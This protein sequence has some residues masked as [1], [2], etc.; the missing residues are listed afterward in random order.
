[1]TDWPTIVI[2]F[3]AAIGLI[4]GILIWIFNIGHTAKSAAEDV[5]DI[6]KRLS[7]VEAKSADVAVLGAQMSMVI[8]RVQALSDTV[9]NFINS[10]IA[11]DR[12]N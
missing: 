9:Q 11:R 1:M 4:G 12:D 2:A 8:E 7:N 6:K 5:A 10:L 3:V